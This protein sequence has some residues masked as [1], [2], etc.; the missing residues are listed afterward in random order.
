V[1]RIR[2]AVRVSDIISKNSRRV[3]SYDS[4]KGIYNLGVGFVWGGAFD[5]P[6]RRFVPSRVEPAS[7]YCQLRLIGLFDY[8]LAY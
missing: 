3:L 4:K 8:F 6:P 7:T 1:G 5:L 2:S